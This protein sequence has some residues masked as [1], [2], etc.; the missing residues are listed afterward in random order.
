MFVLISTVSDRCAVRFVN[1]NTQSI[2]ELCRGLH[3]L[4]Y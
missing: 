3:Y 1:R 4:I 2:E